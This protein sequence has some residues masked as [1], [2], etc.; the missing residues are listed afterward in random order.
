MLYLKVY[1]NALKIYD[2]EMYNPTIYGIALLIAHMS[3][4]YRFT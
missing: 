4:E 1:M 2:L 3:N